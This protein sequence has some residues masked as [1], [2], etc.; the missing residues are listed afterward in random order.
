VAGSIVNSATAVA[1][2][3][4]APNVIHNPLPFPDLD[5]KFLP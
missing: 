1:A 5:K 2:K 3:T 4:N